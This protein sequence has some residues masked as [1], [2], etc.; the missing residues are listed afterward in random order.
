MIHLHM[1]PNFCVATLC[2]MFRHEIEVSEA[3][4]Y[5]AYLP[6]CFLKQAKAKSKR[7]I[8]V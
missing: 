8:S 6:C 5:S 1:H 4:A 7:D 3:H 2:L